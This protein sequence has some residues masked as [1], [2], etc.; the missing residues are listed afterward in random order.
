MTRLCLHSFMIIQNAGRTLTI[1]LCMLVELKAMNPAGNLITLSAKQK[2]Y[3]QQH[4]LWLSIYLRCNGNALRCAF[5]NICTILIIR[6]NLLMKL[7]P[8]LFE[9][10]LGLFLISSLEFFSISMQ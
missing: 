4:P 9:L 8:L 6:G 7:I 1:I 10:L 2:L 3:F 5:P